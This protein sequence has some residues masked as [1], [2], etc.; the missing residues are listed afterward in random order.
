M[1]PEPVK[2][3]KGRDLLSLTEFTS[4]EIKCLLDLAAELKQ[5]QKRGE[6]QASTLIGK[7]LGMIFQKASTRTRVS[8]EVATYQLG[9]YALYLNAN[10]LQLGRGE[11]IADTARVLSRYLDGLVIRTYAQEDVE[12]LALY[13]NIPVINGLSDLYHPCQVLADLQT[14][15]EHKGDLEGLKLAYVGDGNNVCHSLLIAAAKLDLLF[16][17][18][19]PE[20]YPPAEKV[21]ALAGQIARQTGS[22]IEILNSPVEAVANADVIITDVWTS[23]GQEASSKQR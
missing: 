10:D 23:M 18:A 9:G 15:R 11:T 20:E 5:R 22:Q 7:T 8:F 19:T 12:E 3:L 13:A 6:S 1:T 17:V 21:I 14:I 4:A 2:S 16:F